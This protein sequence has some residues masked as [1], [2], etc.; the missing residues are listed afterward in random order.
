MA[1]GFIVGL[2]DSYETIVGE[3][4]VGISGGQ[5][6]RVAI[7]RALLKNAP[8]LILDDS[9]S[10]LDMQTEKRLLHEIS[11]KYQ[12]RTIIISAHRLSSVVDCDEII[13]L[14][15]GKIIERGTFE[16]LMKLILVLGFMISISVPL[17]CVVI[18]IV[19]PMMFCVYALRKSVKKI[20]PEHRAK[21]A[22]RTA[23]IIESIMGEKIIKNFNRTQ[24]S[25]ETYS[26]IHNQSVQVWMRIVR[27]NEMNAPTVMLFWN[28]GMLALYGIAMLLMQKEI[29]VMNAG[30]V[31]VFTNYMSLFSGPMTQIASIIQSLA[32]VSTNMEQVFDTIDQPVF[33]ADSETALH[34]H[35]VNGKVDFDHVYFEYEDGAPVLKD[36]ELHVTPGET[37]VLVGPTGAGKSTV[38]NLLT[39]FYDV[40][41]GSVRID[42]VDVRDV[43]LESLRREVG[44][45]M[46]DPFIFK[47]TVLENIRYGK[48]SATDEECIAAARMIHAEERILALPDGYQHKLDERGQDFVYIQLWNRRKWKS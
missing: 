1:H 6:Q 2:P 15:D 18:G 40:D 30:T 34:L 38:I 44:V 13:Y 5:K 19:V 16:E 9:T 31:V 46:Q 27:R 4:G 14:K 45:L 20:F 7:A 28:I 26:D 8:I 25:K 3:K 48:P 33:I 21:L 17:T 10:A 24:I 11:Q 37:I 22:N 39:R 12:D 41:Q 32:Q 35:D 36:F 23:F 29:S 43:T 47:G 42:G